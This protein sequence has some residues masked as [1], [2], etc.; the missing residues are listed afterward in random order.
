M[1]NTS[2]LTKLGSNTTEYQYKGAN[3]ELLET[4]ENQYPK[5][6]YVTSFV[7]NEI[8]HSNEGQPILPACVKQYCLSGS[9]EHFIFLWINR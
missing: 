2:N 4:F 5:R 3:P 8:I 7:F 9:G 1:D 6:K